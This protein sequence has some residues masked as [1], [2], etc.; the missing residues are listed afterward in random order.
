MKR[1]DNY[2]TERLDDLM[3]ERLDDYTTESR[4]AWF[5]SHKVAESPLLKYLHVNSVI[6][7]HVPRCRVSQSLHDLFLLCEYSLS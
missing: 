7:K 4:V 2:T 1:L 3:T 6:Y 5:Q